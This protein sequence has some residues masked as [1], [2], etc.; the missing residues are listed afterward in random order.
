MAFQIQ[1]FRAGR[2]WA[3]TALEKPMV[4][5]REFAIRGLDRHSAEYAVIKDD[6]GNLI[7]TVKRRS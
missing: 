7:E 6:N 2:L 1:Y 5:T 4:E 3:E